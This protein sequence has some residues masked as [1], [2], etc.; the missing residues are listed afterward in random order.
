M[1]QFGSSVLQLGIYASLMV[2]IMRVFDAVTDP[3]I[4]AQMDRTSTKIGKFRPFMIIGS[5]IMALS[6][7]ALYCCVNRH[8]NQKRLD[9]ERNQAF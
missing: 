5:V 2:T 9:F 7:F 8:M 4:G 1:A 6:V 3:I